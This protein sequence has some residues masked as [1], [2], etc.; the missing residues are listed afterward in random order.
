M[1]TVTKA[2]FDQLVQ[3]NVNAYA[4]SLNTMNGTDQARIDSYGNPNSGAYYRTVLPVVSSAQLAIGNDVILATDAIAYMNLITNTYSQLRTYTLVQ[5]ATGQG[6]NIGSYTRV[7]YRG[8]FSGNS[9][10]TAGQT[11]PYTKGSVIKEA[12]LV[13][14]RAA[15]QTLISTNSTMNGGV[16]YFC[17]ASCHGNC[18]SSR[19]RR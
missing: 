19:G 17:H 5:Y 13:N 16:L 15:I 9:L 12:D 18:H 1:A 4:N 11:A 8:G 14:T 2:T 3:L 10:L 6:P 7:G